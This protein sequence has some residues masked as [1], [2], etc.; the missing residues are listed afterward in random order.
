MEAEMRHYTD[1]FVYSRAL[2]PV[3]SLDKLIDERLDETGTSSFDYP[4]PSPGPEELLERTQAS[5]A[6][7]AFVAS[8]TPRDQEIVQRVFWRGETQTA[9]ANRFRVSKMAISKAMAKISARGRQALAPYRY[10]ALDS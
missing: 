3:V 9:V 2:D 6:V 5:A 7:S 1:A 8:L 4:D 10:L